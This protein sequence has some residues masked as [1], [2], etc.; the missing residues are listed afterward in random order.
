MSVPSSTYFPYKEAEEELQIAEQNFRNSIDNSPLGICIVTAEGELLYANQ[1]LLDIYG[2]SSVEE[3]KATPAR[4]CYAPKSYAEYQERI[5]RKKLRKP[6]PS[7]YEISIVRKDGGIRHLIVSRKAVVWGGELQF[8]TIYQDITDRKRAEHDLSKRMKELQCLYDISE[9]AERP[10]ISADVL[11]HRIANQIPSGWQYPEI[12]CCRITINKKK[13]RTDNYKETEWKQSADIKIHNEAIGKV[14]VNY[15]EERPEIDKGPF[16][17]EERQLINSIAERVGLI[18]ER[19]QTRKTLMESEARLRTILDNTYDVIFQLSPLSIIQYVSPKVKEVYGYEPEDLIGKHLKKT[20]PV[21]ELPKV[22]KA[23][24][25]VLSGKV[26]S[27]LEVDQ[28]DFNGNIVSMEINAAPVIKDGKTIAVQGAMRDIT[29]RKHAEENIKRAAEEWRTT[30]DNIPDLISIHDKGFRVVRSNKA[31]ART[32]KLKP[33]AVVGSICYELIHGTNEPCADCPLR[34]SLTTQKLSRSEFFNPHLG[35]YMEVTCSPIIN[36][37]GDAVASVHIMRDVTEHRQMLETLQGS[38]ERYRLVADN[39][40]DVIWTVDLNMRPTYISP[41]ISRLLGYSAEEAMAKPMEE[42]FTPASFEMAMKVLAEELAIEELEQ[43]DLFRARLLE[44]HMIHKDGSTVPVEIKYTFLRDADTKPV[45]ILAI[46]RDIT[47]RKQAEAKL[48]ESESKYRAIFETTGTAMIIIEEDTKI[49]LANAEFEKLSGYSQG[50]IEGKKSF[51][52]FIAEGEVERLKE[53]HRQRRIN[54][55]AVPKQYETQFVDRKGNI[56]DVYASVDVVPG[57]RRSVAS[58]LDI[59]KRKQTERDLKIEAQLLDNATDSIFVYTPTGNIT[60]ANETAYKSHGYTKEELMAINRRDLATPEYSKLFDA[61]IKTLLAK[62]E[63]TW[64]SA[65]LRKDRSAILVEVHAQVIRTNGKKLILDVARDITERKQMQEQL[66]VADRLATLGELISGIAHE[67]NNPLTSIIGFAQLLLAKDIPGGVK[68]DLKVIYEEAERT[69]RVVRN[70]LAF[71]RRHEPEKK[72]ENINE[73][74]KAVLTLRTYEQKVHNIQASTQFAPDLPEIVADGFQLQQVFLNIIV[75][76][77][78]F[79][80]AAHGGGNLNIT[81][82]RV[83]DKIRASFT[84]DGAGIPQ[85]NLSHLFDPFFTTKDVGRGTGL[86]LSICHG[87]V[88]EHGGSI[89]AQSE[90]GKGATFIIELPIRQKK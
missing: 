29:E 44:I 32:C 57:T 55:D 45:G 64:E 83:G 75:N 21:S 65:H 22:L 88:T 12:T 71:A 72:P 67:L 19:M 38:E 52:E 66:I 77:E 17:K 40:A 76:A 81:T 80:A 47:E 69:S 31:F 16:L 27:N 14:E 84:D 24:R 18:I 73:V 23:L 7:S 43:K 15:L 39:A 85:E 63:T 33:Q 89:Y 51:T 8:Q 78:Y 20:T 11:Y 3:L 70:L 58:I 9:I 87:I 90:L 34:Q 48:K 46:A 2:Y 6:V 79:M 30:F 26:I 4:K 37:N 36:G 82:E 13:Y 49:S 54:P 62:G 5:Q 42:I 61:R 41:S 59:T 10:S 35:I 60:Y 53:Y 74:I 56:K 25:S 68:E 1:A 50:E 86:G 28:M